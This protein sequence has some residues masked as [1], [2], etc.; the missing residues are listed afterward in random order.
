M[1]TLGIKDIFK[2]MNIYYILIIYSLLLEVFKIKK[3]SLKI[4]KINVLNLFRSNK[5]FKIYATYFKL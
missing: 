1:D 5:K 2:G 3:N 4:Y